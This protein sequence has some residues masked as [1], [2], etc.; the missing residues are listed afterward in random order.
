MTSV[1]FKQTVRTWRIRTEA[2]PDTVST[3]P[4]EKCAVFVTTEEVWMSITNKCKLSS[5]LLLL[6]WPVALASATND[7]ILKKRW[8]R[9]WRDEAFSC[10]KLTSLCSVAA[11]YSSARSSR[12]VQFLFEEM[13]KWFSSAVVHLSD[14]LTNKSRLKQQLWM[15]S[16]SACFSQQQFAVTRFDVEKLCSHVISCFQ[17]I[18]CHWNCLVFIGLFPSWCLVWRWCQSSSSHVAVAAC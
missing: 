18:C 1:L 8:R 11:C 6:L 13:I 17:V 2:D 16:S 3:G 5:D 9:R 4:P 12:S 14:V 10:T 15:S 7:F